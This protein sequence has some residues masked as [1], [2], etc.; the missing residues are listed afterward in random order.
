MRY[1][2]FNAKNKE[3]ILERDNLNFNLLVYLLQ[4]CKDLI[5][6]D[7]N[8]FIKRERNGYT[9]SYRSMATRRLNLFRRTFTSA[10][11]DFVYTSTRLRI[12]PYHIN[13]R[14]YIRVYISVFDIPELYIL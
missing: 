9:R 14:T 12:P 5:I 3:E 11:L 13:I 1:L 8:K 10:R 6:L 2:C 4:L 7:E